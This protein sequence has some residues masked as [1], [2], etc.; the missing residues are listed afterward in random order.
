LPPQQAEM[1]IRRALREPAMRASWAASTGSAR[2]RQLSRKQT[3]FHA[4]SETRF[5]FESGRM[6]SGLH[7]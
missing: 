5:R 3:G 4:T 6:R 2:S 1:V 7:R